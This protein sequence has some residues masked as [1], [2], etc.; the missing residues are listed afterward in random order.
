M[1][2]IYLVPHITNK[3]NVYMY[4]NYARNNP[5]EERCLNCKNDCVHKG[6]HTILNSK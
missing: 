6:K 1:R 4:C 5:K 3:D 2:K